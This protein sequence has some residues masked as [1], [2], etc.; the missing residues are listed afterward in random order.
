MTSMLIHKLEMFKEQVSDPRVSGR[1]SMQHLVGNPHASEN[2]PGTF[3][4][5]G[6]Q[7]GGVHNHQENRPA[8][9]PR[10][11]CLQQKIGM[12]WNNIENICTHCI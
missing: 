2:F 6:E 11:L 1:S 9:P 7:T 8:F 4:L 5:G 3:S 10:F 12:P